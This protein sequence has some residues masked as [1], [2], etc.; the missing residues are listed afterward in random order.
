M[1][2]LAGPNARSPLL[3]STEILVDDGLLGAISLA[4]HRSV[5]SRPSFIWTKLI[6]L[7]F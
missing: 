3:R 4:N 6:D 2:I 5:P 7:N 1:S